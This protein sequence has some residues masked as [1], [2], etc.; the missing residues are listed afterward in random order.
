[1]DD[2][3]HVQYPLLAALRIFEVEAQTALTEAKAYCAGDCA[4]SVN[5]E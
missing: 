2:D 1:M 4:G 3:T 5:R